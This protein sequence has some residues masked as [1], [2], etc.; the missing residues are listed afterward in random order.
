MWIRSQ[1]K[2]ILLKAKEIRIE[3]ERRKEYIL[4]KELPNYKPEDVFKEEDTDMQYEL[5]DGIP[6]PCVKKEYRYYVYKSI[7][8]IVVNDK[9]IARYSTEEKA[10]KV[11]DYLQ[12]IIDQQEEFKAQGED[13]RNNTS[14]RRM[15]K[16]V[17]QMPTDEEVEGGEKGDKESKR[18]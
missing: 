11:L 12:E 18:D 17:F 7:G 14:Y 8:Y 16:F 2:K 9:K 6:V 1:D 4:K 10:L 13:R 3:I 5:V 15:I